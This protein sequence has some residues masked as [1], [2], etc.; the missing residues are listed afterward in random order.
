MEHVEFGL[1][2]RDYMSAG[3]RK[4]AV[5]A[6]SVFGEVDK[7][8]DSAAEHMRKMGKS[9]AEMGSGTASAGRAAAA[10]ISDVGES[11][12]KATEDVRRLAGEMRNVGGGN[13]G[14]GSGMWGMM[15]G[16]LAAHV[17]ERGVGMGVE[18]G[19]DALGNGMDLERMKVGLGTFVGAGQANDIVEGV[20]K[21]AIRTPFTSQQLL[22]IETGLISTGMDAGRA[23]RDMM[24]MANAVAATGGSDYML[25]LMGSHLAQAASSGKIDGM[26]KREFQRT[27]HI[28]IDRIVGDYLFPKLSVKDRTKRFVTA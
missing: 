5:A 23:N 6:R 25:E 19:R 20:L 4:V 18:I 14:G 24:A 13:S 21:Q 7:E 12:R 15:R 3:L 17:V 26:T 27:A 9:A 1:S 11:A 28:P 16:S 22:P 2:L 10:G 8:V